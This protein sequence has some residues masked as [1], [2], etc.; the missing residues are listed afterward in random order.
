M[1]TNNKPITGGEFLIRETLSSD[2]FIPEEWSEEQI[3]MK[4]T[5]EEFLAQEVFP[6]LDAIDHQEEGL[7]Q[8]IMDKAGA[9]GL[10]GISVPEDLGGMGMDFKTS[11]LCTEALGMG[12]SF[13][14]AYGAHTGIGTLPILYYGNEEQKK[15]LHTQTRYRRMER[16]LL[17][18][19]TRKRQ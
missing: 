9:L 17:S 12:H 1:S 16:L 10:L 11:M 15:D 18:H 5:C 7:M 2:I 6:K 13:S 8:S 19:R 3:M 4:K 14:V